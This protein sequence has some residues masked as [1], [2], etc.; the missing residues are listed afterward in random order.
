MGLEYPLSLVF[1]FLSL[2]LANSHV[3]LGVNPETSL[4]DVISGGKKI[5]ENRIAQIYTSFSLSEH[6][7]LKTNFILSHSL[8]IARKRGVSLLLA[9]KDD[10]Y[11]E[12]N[13]NKLSKKTNTPKQTL[14]SIDEV[15]FFRPRTGINRTLQGVDLGSNLIN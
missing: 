9:K 7:E 14:R 4:S 13:E 1:F 2:G 6:N 10:Q 8:E 11:I 5:S 3:L 12:I 15:P